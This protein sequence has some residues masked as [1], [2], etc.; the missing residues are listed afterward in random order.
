MIKQVLKSTVLAFVVLA[1][2]NAAAAAE[3]GNL[4]QAH[5]NMRDIAGLQHGAK[6]FM[7][8]CSG[9]HSLKYLRYSRMASDL[10]LSQQEVMDNLD[11]TG[12]KF[13][14]P[15]VSAMPA[16]DAAKWFG[17]APPDLSL[18]VR[19]KGADWVYSYLHGFYLDPSRPVGWNNTVFPNASMPNVLVSLQGI[20]KQV[21]DGEGENGQEAPTKLEL[22]QPGSMTPAQFDDAVRDLTGFLQYA[23][24]PAA[25]KRTSMGVWVILYLALFTLLAYFLKKEFWKDVH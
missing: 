8:Y 2:S 16:E 3:G 15:I 23:A 13:Q 19:A 21:K 11:F 25:M 24:E 5:T 12:A 9:C 1:M 17:K 6:L 14:E 4:Q 10:H 20:Q 18:E 22:A 7:N